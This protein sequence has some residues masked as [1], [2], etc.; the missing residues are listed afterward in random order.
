MPGKFPKGFETGKEF[1][2]LDDETIMAPSGSNTGKAKVKGIFGKTKTYFTNVAKSVKSLTFKIAENQLPNV[3]DFGRSIE[4][5]GRAAKDEFSDLRQKSADKFASMKSGSGAKLTDQVGESLKGLKDDLVKG[6]KT[7]DFTGKEE[8]FNFGDMG[9]DSWDVD[10]GDMDY[11]GS[12]EEDKVQSA[13]THRAAKVAGTAAAKS[14]RAAVKPLVGAQ[15]RGMKNMSHRVSSTI[16]NAAT[17]S[18]RAQLRMSKMSM[19]LSQA[20]FGQHLE[21]QQAI[22]GAVK[23][24]ADYLQNNGARGIEA[25][26]EYMAKAIAMQEDSLALLKE[27]NQTTAVGLN[28]Q[29]AMSMPKD[30]KE[31]ERQRILKNGFDADA[32]FKNIKEKAS[33]ALSNTAIGQVAGMGSMMGE[34]GGMT[35][36]SPVQMGM[37]MI[38]GGLPSMLLSRK[39]KGKLAR[40]NDVFEGMGGALIGKMNSMARHSK[41]P[42]VRGIASVMGVDDTM[43]K[44]ADRGLKDPTG[45]A[46]FDNRV[47]RTLVE[48][49]PGLLSKLLAASSGKEEIYYDMQTGV[50]KTSSSAVKEAKR[51]IDY[52]FDSNA[53]LNEVHNH[54]TKKGIAEAA[55]VKLDPKIIKSDFAQIKKSVIESRESFNPNLA[56]KSGQY[57]QFLLRGL[58][59]K[60]ESLNFYI[61]QFE[62]LRMG[63]QNAYS[64]GANQVFTNMDKVFQDLNQDG[65]SSAVSDF[66]E[67]YSHNLRTT[68]LATMHLDPRDLRGQAAINARETKL[69]Q[70]QS[71]AT[72]RAG[73]VGTFGI[74]EIDGGSGDTS[75]FA[76][77]TSVLEKIHDLL[78]DG[79]IVFPT[80]YGDGNGGHPQ[81]L[82][83]RWHTRNVV[84]KQ[85]RLDKA[86]GDKQ[87]QEQ[88]DL[89]HRQSMDISRERKKQQYGGGQLS[90]GE[91]IRGKIGGAQENNFV[92]KGFGKVGRG[93]EIGSHWLLNGNSNNAGEG[94]DIAEA[95]DR[96]SE[97]ELE[98]LI[99]RAKE[100]SFISHILTTTKDSSSPVGKKIHSIAQWLSLKGG[101]VRAKL[102]DHTATAISDPTVKAFSEKFDSMT[103]LIGT[104]AKKTG[105]FLGEKYNELSGK[106][107]SSATIQKGI[108]SAKKGFASVEVALHGEKTSPMTDDLL[109]SIGREKYHRFYRN[110]KFGTLP[111]R[112]QSGGNSNDSSNYTPAYARAGLSDYSMGMV[113]DS[114]SNNASGRILDVRLVEI[115][116]E[117]LGK[118]RSGVRSGERK[119]S[120]SA[121]APVNTTTASAESRNNLL[122]LPAPT[123]G[124]AVASSVKTDVMEDLIKSTQDIM[125]KMSSDFM[126][127]VNRVQD[128]EQRSKMMKEF[129]EKTTELLDQFEGKLPESL[130]PKVSALRKSASMHLTNVAKQISENKMVISIGR[131]GNRLDNKDWKGAEDEAKVM[132]NTVKDSAQSAA[133]KAQTNIKHFIET[134]KDPVERERMIELELAKVKALIPP[135]VFVKIAPATTF[136]KKLYNNVANTMGIEMTKGKA[137]AKSKVDDVKTWNKE[138][139][140][141]VNNGQT[142]KVQVE[143]W[144][145]EALDK[146]FESF[147]GANHTKKGKIKSFFDKLGRGTG[148]PNALQR[149]GLGV[150]NLAF[151]VGGVVAGA[152][153]TA[154]SV[155]GAGARGIG[156]LFGG[157]GKGIADSHRAHKAAKEQA[158]RGLGTLVT[159]LIGKTMTLDEALPEVYAQ[160]KDG[161]CTM[162]EAA[163]FLDEIAK[164]EGMN[165]TALNKILTS[166]EKDGLITPAMRTVFNRNYAE[167]GR[168]TGGMG[169]KLPGDN[170]IPKHKRKRGLM[171][172][173]GFAASKAGGLVATILGHGF[174][175]LG[176]SLGSVGTL[177]S[178]VI[179]G[180]KDALFKSHIAKL[181]DKTSKLYPKDYVSILKDIPHKVTPEKT[182]SILFSMCRDD[183]K[184]VPFDNIVAFGHKLTVKQLI[185]DELYIELLQGFAMADENLKKPVDLYIKRFKKNG[186]PFFGMKNPPDIFQGADKPGLISR[187]FATA[188]TAVGGVANVI[189]GGIH[190]LGRGLHGL[191]NLF[192][193]DKGSQAERIGSAEQQIRMKKGDPN[194]AILQM[195]V[196]VSHITQILK[197]IHGFPM[198][199]REFEKALKKNGKGGGIGGPSLMGDIAGAVGGLG[200]GLGGLGF[201]AMQGGKAIGTKMDR[202]KGMDAGQATAS[203]TGVGSASNYDAQ[204][205]EIDRGWDS[206][207]AQGVSMA[208]I[209]AGIK[210]IQAFNAVAGGGVKRAGNLVKRGI[211]LKRGVGNLMNKGLDPKKPPKEMLA[212][213]KGKGKGL[214]KTMMDFVGKIFDHDPFKK[215]ISKIMA[216]KLISKVMTSIAESAIKRAAVALMEKVAMVVSVVATPL[217]IAQLVADFT[218]GMAQANRYFSMGKGGEPNLA[219]RLSSGILNMLSGFLCG[220]LPVEIVAPF[221]YGLFASKAD[222]EYQES[223]RKFVEERAKLL[224]VEPARLIEYET[225]TWDE[226]LFG[227]DEKCRTILGF[228]TIA[229]YI[230]WR[231]NQY[232]PAMDAYERIKGQMGGSTVENE[233]NSTPEKE[234]QERFREAYLSQARI[235]ASKAKKTPPKEDSKAG[236]Y[237]NG[238]ASATSKLLSASGAAPAVA[239]GAVASAAAATGLS[240]TGDKIEPTNYQGILGAGSPEA[241]NVAAGLPAG[242]ATATVAA[243]AGIGTATTGAAIAD[244]T[245]D[246]DEKKDG[247]GSLSRSPLST[248]AKMQTGSINEQMLIMNSLHDEQKR[249]NKEV[250][251]FF[252]FFS[253][254]FSK[255]AQTQTAD[256]ET[257]TSDKK[258]D[259]SF[260]AMLSKIGSPFIGDQNKP[261]GQRNTPAGSKNPASPPSAGVNEAAFNAYGAQVRANKA[262]ATGQSQ[263]LFANAGATNRGADARTLVAKGT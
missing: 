225:M 263:V 179:T 254:A 137:W 259:D 227:A 117:A 182:M 193:G 22:F 166:W 46:T 109:H 205:N 252:K 32:Y 120:A 24:I 91:L 237:G 153:G 210:G 99:T 25:N 262:A 40:V 23:G 27:L 239:A 14:T 125:K 6:F 129:R 190:A 13:T 134:I 5:L 26:M 156:G 143:G 19:A 100:T 207:S 48:V 216:N 43:G 251:N 177:A 260:A 116:S 112:K 85:K 172:N 238:T 102:A 94:S 45:R 183:P 68:G 81:H 28:V 209:P 144:S 41:N 235:I 243:A 119:G 35:N 58:K 70:D 164:P 9:D 63:D 229:E 152:V 31:S 92:N 255:F 221:L 73:R 184:R 93:L 61:Q 135:D 77:Q 33:Q 128:P 232:Q 17:A 217:L 75:G 71:N 101:E 180:V 170:K 15:I 3:V 242:G 80:Q 194:Q 218:T 146:L 67:E 191:G 59:G 244:A 212:L 226:K 136:I 140:S 195:A 21:S 149:V 246:G 230:F 142:L 158:K 247:S 121:T 241:A 249:H 240:S 56:R 250:E 161:R 167:T 178:K 86:V 197:K 257:D 74:S 126:N 60:D 223:S 39:T 29:A 111:G 12:S 219:M 47:H 89:I 52:T 42:I 206:R 141:F 51:K 105:N 95:M 151:G 34:M 187:A 62:K 132:W 236:A 185:S 78:T 108:A 8:E 253:L 7:G 231:D 107:K 57:R 215:W 258:D 173:I 37:D 211:N 104:E 145:E 83:E 4:D 157:F 163:M 53:M 97:G 203:V 20:Q 16:V 220:L 96:E 228:K 165:Y 208:K 174:G 50:F 147:H 130:R 64:S 168:F 148:G 114:V 118:I 36:K 155:V 139:T 181:Q 38:L 66:T 87:E 248:D 76:S 18:T 122:M 192:R 69:K 106:I 176:L 131:M 199:K 196:N 84:D 224:G 103:K 2:P 90:I 171:G 245:R 213:E 234:N 198:T 1:F 200:I 123:S 49:I 201:M 150:G 44:R 133:T 169:I 138:R 202:M 98:S 160:L 214:L 186:D 115:S 82:K 55:D 127:Q 233:P 188:K 124:T 162:E 54:M 204:G 72:R 159:K 79:I 110:K 256:A 65:Q 154:G 88:F 175:A 30:M 10:L 11:E 261:G 113:N 189:M 222:K